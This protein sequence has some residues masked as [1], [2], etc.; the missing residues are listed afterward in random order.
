MFCPKCGSQV[1][2]DAEFCFSCGKPVSAIKGQIGLKVTKPPVSTSAKKKTLK[3]LPA[4]VWGL[5]LAVVLV[6]S[7]VMASPLLFASRLSKEEA[8]SLLVGETTLSFDLVLKE[9]ELEVN[10]M[11]DLVF[12]NE[13]CVLDDQIR[14][15][16]RAD[17]NVLAGGYYSDGNPVAPP[18]EIVENIIEFPSALHPQEILELATE[19]YYSRDC[20]YNVENNLGFY[21]DN[22][23]FTSNTYE[24]GLDN[25][26]RA[27]YFEI[28][29][30]AGEFSGYNSHANL[31]VADGKYLVQ[32]RVDGYTSED[33]GA[34]KQVA[35]MVLEKIYRDRTSLD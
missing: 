27:I 34:A 5:T 18:K 16:I 30:R 32:I 17:G 29:A 28:N 26:V 2:T 7:T 12:P 33:E 22:I 24:L 35:L 25:S 14:D 19:G 8:E 11:S 1:L 6:V 20:F 4:L 9:Y 15:V 23:N 21:S 31:L 10:M 3:R 13:T